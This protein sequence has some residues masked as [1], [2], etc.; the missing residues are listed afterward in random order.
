MAWRSRSFIALFIIILLPAGLLASTHFFDRRPAEA[1]ALNPADAQALVRGGLIVDRI[2]QNRAVLYLSDRE[3]D[4]LRGAGY[5]IEFLPDLARERAQ[6]L[7]DGLDETDD[8]HTYET[9]TAELQSI[10]RDNP[11]LTRLSSIGQSVQGRELWLMEI[12]DNVL[13]EEEEPEFAYLS[14]MHGDEV[15]G[16]ENCMQFIHYLL[17]NY[18]SNTEIQ[19]LIDETHIYI[20]PSIN[21][22]GTVVG[23]RFNANGVDLNRNF[24]DRIADPYDWELDREPET[25][26]MMGFFA[27]HSPVLAANFHGG[28]YVVNYPWDTN[29]D[30]Q[31]VYTICPDDTWY[32][33]AGLTYASLNP[34][35]ANSTQFPNGITNGAD[36][37]SITGGMQ[38]WTYKWRGCLHFTIELSDDHWPPADDLPTYWDDNRD[39]MIEL[40]HAAHQGIRGVVTDAYTGEPV[41]ASITLGDNPIQVF[42]DPDLGDYYR[43]ADP[44][45]HV[46]HIEAPGYRSVSSPTIRVMS[47]SFSRYDVQLYPEVDPYLAFDFEEG[48]GEFTHGYATEGF[49]DQ[50][51][52]S[53]MRSNSGSTAWKCGASGEGGYDNDLDAVLIS[54]VIEL[55]ANTELSFWQFVDTEISATH[56]PE[57][58][59]GARLEILPEGET[60]WILLTP[61]GGY[62]HTVRNTDGNTALP[63]DAP[64]WAGGI[65]GLHTRFD[66]SDYAGVVQLRWRFVSDVSVSREGWYIDDAKFRATDGGYLAILPG[67]VEFE[68]TDVDASSELTVTLEN[69]GL[70]DLTITDIQLDA[71]FSSNWDAETQSSIASGESIS[72]TLTFSPGSEGVHQG[73][74]VVSYDDTNTVA[75]DLTGTALPVNSVDDPDLPTEFAISSP[76][77]NP[78]NSSVSVRVSLPTASDVRISLFNLL[79]QRVRDIQYGSLSAGRHTLHWNGRSD[80][81]ANVSSGQYF[82][83]LRAGERERVIPV[84][85]IR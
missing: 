2:Q 57:A 5:T 61:I 17:D 73:Q 18:D 83:R 79:G 48:V 80:S 68:D 29:P 81:G 15:V 44:G 35:M 23:A 58:Y 45:H 82:L 9:L 63:Q 40:M 84:S 67:R 13:E 16:K 41:Y 14:S 77:P 71:P 4:S 69:R 39:A 64:I 70:S 26:A 55:Q 62:E 31:A 65:N 60:E 75:V 74:M 42:P 43:L 54:P 51:H 30:G 49:G 7:A 33:N 38:D 10:A 36:W 50:W 21:P 76:W 11:G 85:L 27:A 78:F 22:D 1:T 3:A 24:P 12:S 52:L 66:L 53:T 47:G 32:I 28:V 8:Y 56:Y 34:M 46:L 25:V 37:Y 72:L 19:N 20:V 59:D 6:L